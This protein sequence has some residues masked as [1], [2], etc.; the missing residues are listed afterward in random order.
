MANEIDI[1]SREL[2]RYIDTL[3]AFWQ[4]VGDDWKDVQTTWGQVNQSWRGPSRP[5][6]GP[7]GRSPMQGR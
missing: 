2:R 7:A 4:S 6:P 5:S 3:Y 1:D